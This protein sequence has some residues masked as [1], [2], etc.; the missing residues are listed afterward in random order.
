M[1]EQI[2]LKTKDEIAKMQK[3]GAILIDVFAAMREAIKPGVSTKTLDRIAYDIITKAGAKPSFLNYGDPPFKGSVCASVNE[4]VVHGVPSDNIVLK[5]GDIIT[6]DCGACLDGW[7]SDAARTF[8][9]GD[10]KPEVQKLVQVTEESFYEGLAFA[11]PGCRLGDMQAAIQKHIDKHGYGIV[12]ELTGHGIGRSLHEGPSIPNY[13]V[14]GR[15]VRLQAGMVIAV[16]PMVT[17]GKARIYLGDDEWSIITAD[18][19]PAAH[20]ENTIA[21]TEDG[22]I[23]LTK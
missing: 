3:S 9:V 14:A 22:P 7:H 15:G 17:L 8:L 11:K 21:I 23:L 18:G 6:I 20:Y 5:D 12:R 4:V 13:G 16:E 10:V 1:S 2:F 19:L